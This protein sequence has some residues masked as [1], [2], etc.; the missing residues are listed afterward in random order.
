MSLDRKWK[1]YPRQRERHAKYSEARKH[2]AVWDAVSAARAKGRVLWGLRLGRA[3]ACGAESL[4]VSLGAGPLEV[5]VKDGVKSTVLQASF[6][7]SRSGWPP[8]AVRVSVLWSTRPLSK[9]CVP[10]QSS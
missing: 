3:R 4:H 9:F 10:A 1:L 2:G 6:Y 7:D 8:V 5:C